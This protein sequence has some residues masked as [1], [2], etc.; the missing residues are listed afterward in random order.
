MAWIYLLLDGAFEVG[1]TTAFRFV[2][3]WRPWPILVFLACAAASLVLLYKALEGI[4]VGTAYA[5]WTGVGAAGTVLLGIMFFKEPADTLRLF[6][7]VTL[8]ASILGLKLVSS[9]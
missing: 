2:D 4:P 8:I 1:C 7:L 5:V 9:H 6:F 3:G